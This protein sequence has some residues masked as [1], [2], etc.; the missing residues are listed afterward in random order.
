MT[1]YQRNR[2]RMLEYQ[3]QYNTENKEIVLGYQKMYYIIYRDDIIKSRTAKP[4]RDK[5]AK[6]SSK[7]IKE[8]PKEPKE[9]VEVTRDLYHAPKKIVIDTGKFVLSFD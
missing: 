9:S 1:Y 3:K 7:E 2:M 4:K 5:K 6:E 8:E